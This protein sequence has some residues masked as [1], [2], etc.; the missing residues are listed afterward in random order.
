VDLVEES[1]PLVAEKDIEEE[2]RSGGTK[3]EV[4]LAELPEKQFVKHAREQS[5]ELESQHSVPERLCVVLFLET[6]A[7]L[8]I[9]IWHQGQ[10]RDT[11]G[12]GTSV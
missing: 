9:S 2:F 6:L 12:A 11:F 10:V 5:S 4:T 8:R 3:E 1:E 7:I